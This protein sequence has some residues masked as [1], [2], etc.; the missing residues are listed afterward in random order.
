MAVGIGEAG[1]VA[2]V[3]GVA[4]WSRHRGARAFCVCD[5]LPDL[6][7]GAHVVGE[8]DT[9]EGPNVGVRHAAV[10]RQLLPAPEHEHRGAGL[11]EDGLLDLLALPAQLLVER[12]GATQVIDT[13]GDQADSLLHRS[14]VLRGDWNVSL[15]RHVTRGGLDTR[16]TPKPV[17]APPAAVKATPTAMSFAV[18]G[19]RQLAVGCWKCDGAHQTD[20]GHGGLIVS[21]QQTT[22]GSQGRSGPSVKGWLP[23]ML[24]EGAMPYAAYL[25]LR[26]R[27]VGSVPALAA[28]A[29]FPAGFILVRFVRRRRLDGFGLIVLAVITIGVT[30]S[31]LSGDARFALVKESA[32]T[33]AFGLAMLGSLAARRPLMFYSGRK[34]ATDGSPEGIARWESYW[35][36]SAMFRHSNRMMTAVWGTVFLAEAAIRVV[37][38]YTLATSTAVALSAVVPLAV[39]A[40]LIAWTVSYSKR[41]R[42]VSLAEVVAYDAV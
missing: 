4:R 26:G 13:Q 41:T 29:V 20:D 10:L 3:E 39:V 40:L 24:V 5:D 36:K 2:A 31:L 35:T 1:G 27:G 11:E 38:A 34:F 17:T 21:A 22:A 42:P 16:L 32:L 19:S 6:V 37:A 12:T 25:I 33:G 15:P 18:F 28:G 23:E 7:L 14:N 8:Y 30:L 9:V